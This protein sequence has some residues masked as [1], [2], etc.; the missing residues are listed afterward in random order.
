[1]DV[2]GSTRLDATVLVDGVASGPVSAA[3][4]TISFWGGFD[5]ST[6]IVIDRRHSLAGRC[7]TGTVFVLPRGKGSSTGSAVLLDALMQGTAPAAILLNRVDE[8]IVLGAVVYEEFFGGTLPV[9]V[10]RDDHFAV[11]LEAARI[12]VMAGGTVVAR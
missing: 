3:R 10:L 4:D 12:D 9:A 2:P 1:M 7:L 5:P 6:G 8:I 11:A